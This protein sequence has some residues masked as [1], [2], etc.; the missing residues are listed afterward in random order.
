MEDGKGIARKSRKRRV[1]E[2]PQTPFERIKASYGVDPKQIERLEKLKA[3][4][5]PF[6]LKG[7]IEKKLRRVLR[8]PSPRSDKMAA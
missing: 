3:T 4:L 7:S 1:S 6:W 8:A 5:N 2:K